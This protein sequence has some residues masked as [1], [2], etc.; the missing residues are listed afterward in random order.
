MSTPPLACIV[1]AVAR[2]FE[3]TSASAIDNAADNG[4]AVNAAVMTMVADF[5]GLDASETIIVSSCSGARSVSISRSKSRHLKLRA[6]LK[7]ARA[8]KPADGANDNVNISFWSSSAAKLNDNGGLPPSVCKTAASRAAAPKVTRNSL[9]DDINNSPTAV[10][11]ASAVA[12]CVFGWSSSAINEIVAVVS[13][14]EVSTKSVN[15][16]SIVKAAPAP[17]NK[18]KE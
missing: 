11:V 4:I 2:T 3:V 12:G 13:A 15:A 14:S 5:C 9:V 1:A 10:T 17:G 8:R 6:T 18:N 7:V 16:P